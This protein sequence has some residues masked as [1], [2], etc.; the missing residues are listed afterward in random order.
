MAGDLKQKDPREVEADNIIASVTKCI[1]RGEG[2]GMCHV[3]LDFN[4][5]CQCGKIDLA[6]ARMK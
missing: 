3:F 5:I 1:D 6:K 4:D 2:K